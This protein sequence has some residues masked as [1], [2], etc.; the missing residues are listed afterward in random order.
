ME[1]FVLVITKNANSHEP[2]IGNI[3]KYVD[4]ETVIDQT[5]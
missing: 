4:Y 2:N 5:V 3:K 1:S